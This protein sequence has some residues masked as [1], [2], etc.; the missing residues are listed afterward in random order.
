MYSY[1]SYLSFLSSGIGV[2]FIFFLSIRFHQFPKTYWL[3]SI[4]FAY[5][6]LTPN[7]Q[8]NFDGCL[9]PKVVDEKHIFPT[10]DEIF[11]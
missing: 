7:V 11:L 4:I 3:I 9:M 8:E 10:L 2:F 5:F 6:M 1:I